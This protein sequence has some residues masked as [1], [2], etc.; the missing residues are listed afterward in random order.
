MSS[1]RRDRDYFNAC[2]WGVSYDDFQTSL[3]T[4]EYAFACAFREK[5]IQVNGPHCGLPRVVRLIS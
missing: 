4:K 1:I 5:L 2:G 3:I